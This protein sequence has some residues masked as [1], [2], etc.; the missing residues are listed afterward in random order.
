MK[1]FKNSSGKFI[2]ADLASL[3]AAAALPNLPTDFRVSITNAPGLDSYPISSF[4]WFLAPLPSH[5]PSEASDLVAFFRWMLGS[6]PQR[7]AGNRGYAPLPAELAV[8]VQLQISK[9]R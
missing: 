4:V 5:S 2:T 9:I 6:G 7:Y 1:A 8:R 3:T